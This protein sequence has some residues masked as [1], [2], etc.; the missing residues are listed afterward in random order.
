M[1]KDCEKTLGQIVKNQYS[2]KLE[3]YRQIMCYGVAFY[4]K[5]AMVKKL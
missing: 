4:K 3:G 2:E 1:E 5:T